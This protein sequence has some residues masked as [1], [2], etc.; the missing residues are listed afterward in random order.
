M[1]SIHELELSHFL[2]KNGVSD[3]LHLPNE[4]VSIH[5]RLI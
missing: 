1:L 4:R 3:V 2:A 5:T